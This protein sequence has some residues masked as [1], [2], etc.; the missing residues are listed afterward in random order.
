MKANLADLD[1]KG[2]RILITG[3][4]GFIGGRIVEPLTLEYGASVRVLLRNYVSAFRIAR[5]PIETVW[6][7]IGNPDDVLKAIEG[8]DIVIHCAYGNS[9]DVESRRQANVEGTRNV[10]EAARQAGCR[11]FVHMSTIQVYGPLKDGEL[12]ETKPR[13][14]YGDV[15]SDS[16]L[17][18][19]K[20]A[21]EYHEKHGLPVTIIQPTVVYG[22]FATGWTSGVLEALKR[23]RQILVNG[24]DGLCNAV[25]IDDLVSA[26]L[27]AA[28]REEAVGESFLISDAQPT[29]W[30]EF[31]GSYEKMLGETSTISMSADEADAVSRRKSGA[32]SI[33][34]ESLRIFAGEGE[35][36]QRVLGTREAGFLYRSVRAVLPDAAWDSLRNRFVHDSNGTTAASDKPILPLS[37]P[38]D[39]KF[40]ASRARVSI[41]KARHLLG[42]DPVFDLDSGMAATDKWCRWM[43]LI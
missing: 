35:I 1:F 23:M 4:T 27:L 16:K 41:E 31:Y 28:V 43:N 21:M 26:T 15:Y 11:R 20:L 13:R 40:Y 33:V 38:L 24:G 7:D 29:T 37:H 22:P 25:Y 39:A 2:Q 8:C 6:G 18:A 34:N 3:G 32:P 19:E 36:R 30:R 10:L 42:Y 12:D 5:C 9:G 14:Y 17:D